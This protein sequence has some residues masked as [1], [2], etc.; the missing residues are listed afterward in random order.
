M[1]NNIIIGVLS[2]CL[3]IAVSSAIYFWYAERHKPPVSQ[4][5]YIKVPEVKTVTKIQRIEIPGP[6]RIVTIE[7]PVIIEK[8]KLPDWVKDADKQI[9]ATAEISP[10]DGKTNT[11]AILDTT[12]GVAEIIAKQEPP[13]FMAFTNNKELGI[14]AGYA[15]TPA[16]RATVYGR[17]GFARVGKIHLGVY[18]EANSEG[19]GMAQLEVSYRF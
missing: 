16:A 7:K 19:E 9:I 10:Y 17:W 3:L 1:K 13:A 12:T 18:A 14:R 8:L 15:S 2:A 11:V 6:E 4:I 5:E